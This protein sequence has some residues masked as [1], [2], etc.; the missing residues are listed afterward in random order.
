MNTTIDKALADELRN[1]SLKISELIPS[2]KVILFGSYARGAQ[3]EDSDLD[4]CVLVPETES[5]YAD[6]RRMIRGAIRNETN[7]SLDVL[8]YSFDDFEYSSQYKSR[9]P[10]SIKEE[11]V[12]LNA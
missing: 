8:V 4:L 2:S 11:G 12:V 1:I 7:L 10:H 5:S 6:I 3:T 9:L